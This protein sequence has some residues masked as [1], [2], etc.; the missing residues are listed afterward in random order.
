MKKRPL[1]VSLISWVYIAAGVVGI[2]VH[3]RELSTQGAFQTDAI[4]VVLVPLLAI[5]AGVYMLRGRNWARWLAVA[6]VAFHVLLS[7][8]HS[9][10]QLAVHAVMLGVF[11]YFL[12][13]PEATE[14]F[15]ATQ[16]RT[17]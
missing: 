4:W 15:R 10:Q 16:P 7:A 5:A 12:F 1:P 3:A 17:P 2:A 8:F 14:Y 11:A 9:A 13:R 6:W